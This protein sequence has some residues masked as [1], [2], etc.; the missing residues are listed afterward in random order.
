VWIH[1]EPD[2]QIRQ[3]WHQEIKRVENLSGSITVCRHPKVE[4]LGVV[5]ERGCKT[6]RISILQQFDA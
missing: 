2:S 3:M 6:N 4:L 5:P 1:D